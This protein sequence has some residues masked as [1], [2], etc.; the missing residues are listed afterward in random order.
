LFHELP[1]R[2]E[3]CLVRYWM[4]GWRD[5]CFARIEKLAAAGHDKIVLR[6]DEGPRYLGDDEDVPNLVAAIRK[7]FPSEQFA[8]DGPLNRWGMRSSP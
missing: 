8:V 3:L 7:R 5:L 2:P 6:L 1:D 4:P